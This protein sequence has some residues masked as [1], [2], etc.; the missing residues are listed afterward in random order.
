MNREILFRG[1]HRRK[2]EKVK[3]D[4]TPVESKWVYIDTES[5]RTDET[6]KY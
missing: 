5:G 2:G 4:G 3:L 6:G 1:Q